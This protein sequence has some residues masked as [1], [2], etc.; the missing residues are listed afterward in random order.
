V[1]AASAWGEVA[2]RAPATALG[3]RARR[4]ALPY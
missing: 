3:E 4:R 2:R 1:D